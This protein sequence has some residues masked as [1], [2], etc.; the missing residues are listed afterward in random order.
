MKT[1]FSFLQVL[2]NSIKKK[3][4]EKQCYVQTDFV[5]VKLAFS[6]G[7]L[8]RRTTHRKVGLIS[9]FQRIKIESYVTSLFNQ[10]VNTFT[11][12]KILWFWPFGNGVRSLEPCFWSLVISDI[13]EQPY[14]WGSF[15]SVLVQSPMGEKWGF[16]LW[17]WKQSSSIL[18]CCFRS[19]SVKILTVVNVP[20]AKYCKAT[21]S[22]LII[23]LN[24]THGFFLTTPN[25]H[26]CG[27]QTKE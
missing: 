6:K 9:V 1:G 19:F 23:P 14:P 21:P 5:F 8:G 7:G 13:I 25:P 27:C 22:L 18:F 26:S 16:E 2:Q 10:C 20:S 17:I 24:F 15:S 3:K 12:Y 11:Y 4:K